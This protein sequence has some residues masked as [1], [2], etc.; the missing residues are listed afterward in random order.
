MSA[1]VDQNEIPTTASRTEFGAGRRLVVWA[2][3]GE[4]PGGGRETFYRLLLEEMFMAQGTAGSSFALEPGNDTIFLQR[5]DALEA[6][7]YGG[8][9]AMFE[10]FLNVRAHWAR[11]VADFSP[12]ASELTKEKV[13]TEAEITRFGASGFMQV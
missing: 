4:L 10:T 6:M 13:A 2:A 7:D 3:V 1:T 8:F 12:L 5:T 9:K 11:L